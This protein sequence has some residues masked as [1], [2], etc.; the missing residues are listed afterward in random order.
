M[1]QRRVT[2][3]GVRDPPSGFE[4]QLPAPAHEGA[5]KGSK[6][7]NQADRRDSDG[8]LASHNIEDADRSC[9]SAAFCILLHEK[10]HKREAADPTP[11][12]QGRPR[13]AR[14]PAI[15]EADAGLSRG[16]SDG[17]EPAQLP[18]SHSPESAN[19]CQ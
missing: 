3:G 19:H 11:Q 9:G 17:G 10:D 4:Q 13:E 15:G 14:V 18:G 1:D 16:P 2:A 12:S 7:C 8:V 6:E 5:N